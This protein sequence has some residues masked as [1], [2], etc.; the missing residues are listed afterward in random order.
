MLVNNP[1]QSWSNVP[2]SNSNILQCFERKNLSSYWSTLLQLQ[3]DI[4]FCYHYEE[5]IIG[6]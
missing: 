5:K 2:I 6:H 4:I 1:K 3:P